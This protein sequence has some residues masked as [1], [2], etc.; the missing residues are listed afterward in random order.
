M[1]TNTKTTFMIKQFQKKWNLIK[2]DGSIMEQHKMILIGI[3]GTHT[4]L[5][6]NPKNKCQNVRKILDSH[7]KD[8]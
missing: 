1:C 8:T 2:P 3:R 4:T 6:Q 7:K 5:A